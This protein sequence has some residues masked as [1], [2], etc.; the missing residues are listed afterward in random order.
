MENPGNCSDELYDIMRRCWQEEVIQRPN[1]AELAEIFDKML[2]TK[3]VSI[4]AERF[5]YCH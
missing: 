4:N 3:V 2:Q 1:F 5:S